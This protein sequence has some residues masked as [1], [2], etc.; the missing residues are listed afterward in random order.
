MRHN[1]VIHLIYVDTT[2]D[3]IGNPVEVKTERMVYANQFEVSSTEF[4]EASAQGL[5]PE[6]QFEIYSFEYQ[7][8][9]QLK[10][11]GQVFRVV[12]AATRGEKTRIT[13]QKVTGD[14]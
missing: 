2:Y 10:H 9:E 8:E 3:E 1:D 14:G 12:R 4:Y 11:D 5:K 7:G 6:K 13:C